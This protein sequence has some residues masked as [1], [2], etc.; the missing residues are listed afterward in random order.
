MSYVPLLSEPRLVSYTRNIELLWPSYLGR[1]KI[2]HCFHVLLIGGAVTLWKCI[3]VVQNFGFNSWYLQ[4]EQ[5]RPQIRMT[6][7]SHLNS[8]MGKWAGGGC[9]KKR[10][11]QRLHE[12]V[13][14]G[15]PDNL[16]PV[17]DL[18]SKDGFLSRGLRYPFVSLLLKSS[19]KK[20]RL[21]TNKCVARPVIWLWKGLWRVNIRLMRG[22]FLLYFMIC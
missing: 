20:K 19:K 2:L 21:K 3:W 5:K 14:M 7:A 13:E 16:K 4:K 8:K 11:V 22:L 6:I 12:I 18:F 1:Q 17:T 9:R 10:Q 15:T